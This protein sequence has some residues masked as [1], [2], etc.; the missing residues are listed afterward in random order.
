VQPEVF[1]FQRADHPFGIRI[2]LGVVVAGKYLVDSQAIAGVPECHR[3]GLTAI[4]THQ[5]Q[6]LP[7]GSLRAL[8]IDRP[9]QGHQPLLGRASQANLVPHDLFAVPIE[10]HDDVPPKPSPRTFVMSMP[11]HSS[12]FVGLGL[13]RIGVRL[14]FSR[15]LGETRR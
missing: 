6:P 10:P 15:P 8:A 7:A 5:A 1:R 11:H 13:L 2:A 4:L 12:G 14:A 3:G 9:V